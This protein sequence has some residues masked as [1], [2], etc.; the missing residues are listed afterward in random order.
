MTPLI[1]VRDFAS[2][3]SKYSI[4]LKRNASKVIEVPRVATNDRRISGDLYPVLSSKQRE[5]SVSPITDYESDF[6]G[7]FIVEVP[8]R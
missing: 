8:S 4:Y 2:C 3:V 6:D 7:R 1:C 5:R